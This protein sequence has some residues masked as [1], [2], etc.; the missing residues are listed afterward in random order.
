MEQLRQTE[1]T[2]DE[3]IAWAL[4]QA[5]GRFELDNGTIVA[6]APERVNHTRAKRNAVIAL[7]NAIGVR[8]L[9]CEVLPDG[10]SVRVNERTIY[11]PDA[12]IRCGPPS[13]GDAIEVSDPVIVVEVVSPS[14]RGIDTGAKLAGYFSL[15]S[16][17]HY[18]I[19]DTDKRVVVHHRRD[20]TGAIGVGILHEG[21]L[22]LEPPGLTVE[23]R[24]LFHGV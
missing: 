16:V 22:P 18:L 4:E 11:E 21:A 2:A 24:E 15:P 6:M 17:R 1:L 3:F 19:V 23:V 7:N 13:P 14:S 10:A 20:E 5:T 8:G 12:L 9:A